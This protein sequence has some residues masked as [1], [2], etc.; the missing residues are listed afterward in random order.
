MIATQA[1]CAWSASSTSTFITAVG[2]TSGTGNGSV[3]FAIQNN[4][5]EARSGSVQVAGHTVT[6]QQAAGSPQAC[7]FALT[8]AT[9]PVMA[10]GGDVSIV[11]A[12]TRGD[13]CAWTATSNDTFITVKQGATGVGNGTVVL[14]VA[15]NQG[16]S[17]TGSATIAGGSVS[18]SQDAA[19]VPTPPPVRNPVAVLRYVSDAT[20]P[21]GGG[22]SA[23]YTLTQGQFLLT[24][25]LSRRVFGFSMSPSAPATWSLQMNTPNQI[26][27]GLYSIASR[28]GPVGTAGISFLSAGQN[29]TWIQGRF[30]ISEAEYGAAGAF[31]R[32]HARFEQ[33]CNG[34]SAG[35]HGE[36]WYD[37]GGITTP[38]PLPPFP[39]SSP[40]T[41]FLTIQSDPGDF[42]GQG[43]SATYTLP[44]ALFSQSLTSGPRVIFVVTSPAGMASPAG[45]RWQVVLEAGSGTQLTPGVYDP[46]P[47]APGQPPGSAGLAVEGQFSGGSGRG[48]G[49]SS[50]KFTVH[51]AVYD[52]TGAILRFHATFE[53]HCLSAVPALRGEIRIV[54]DP[55]R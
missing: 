36:I 23:T 3:R 54:A 22:Q 39:P 32:F 13:N 40:P 31:D 37:S 17:R 4:S 20:D 28:F 24:T 7:D 8:P 50:G 26:F 15:A 6:V 9:V 55:W 46:A 10:P 53:Q 38:P 35:L 29:C 16:A 48:C 52:N 34:S 49:S 25:D 1:G 44:G 33:H 11:V 14:T 21:I 43:G 42:V 47:H 12:V 41:T 19:P 5:G 45:A 18:V 30:L 51:E 27:A 2:T